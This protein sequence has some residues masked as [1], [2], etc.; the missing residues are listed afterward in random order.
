MN[1]QQTPVARP[2]LNDFLADRSWKLAVVAHR[3]AWHGAPENSIRS[4]E[5]AIRNGYEF[6]EIDVQATADGQL[7]CIHDDSVERMT[8]QPHVVAQ[9]EAADLTGLFLKE[10]AG[11][12]NAEFTSSLPALLGDLLNVSSDRIYV[13]IDVKH[14]RD[15]EVVCEYVRSHQSRHHIN[16]KTVVATPKDLEYLDNLERRT[17]LL[18]KPVLHV[19]GDTLE[20]FLGFLQTRPTPLVEILCDTWTTFE[21]YAEAAHRAG[22]DLFL[23]T[24]DEVPSA[25]VTDTPSLSDPDQGWGR[26]MRQGARLLQTDHP[27]ALKK[28]ADSKAEPASAI[29]GL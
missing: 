18:I 2:P 29:Q 7:V 22:T 24:L 13:D 12:E 3:G 10:G 17:G 25:V 14:F 16:L 8:G 9:S 19:T 11:G 27:E 23:N 5:L 28:Y 21:R 26:L 15:L 4:V 6:V 1:F 20:T